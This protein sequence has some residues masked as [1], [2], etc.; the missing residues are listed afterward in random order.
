MTTIAFMVHGVREGNPFVRLAIAYAPHP[1]TGLLMI[2]MVALAMAFYCW[3][4]GRTR[5]L[6]RMN[7]MFAVVVAWNLIALILA[8]GRIA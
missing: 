8:A 1:L 7:I 6:N 5:I 4:F 2:K 3:K